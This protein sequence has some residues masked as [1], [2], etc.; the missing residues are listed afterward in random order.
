MNATIASPI[1]TA[2]ARLASKRLLI[3][4]RQKSS[5]PWLFHGW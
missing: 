5:I 2:Q 3:T 4:P 1:G